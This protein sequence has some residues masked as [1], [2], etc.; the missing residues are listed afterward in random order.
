MEACISEEKLSLRSWQH[1]HQAGRDPRRNYL[2]PRCNVV[3]EILL[4]SEQTIPSSLN[5]MCD[6]DF[7][8][9]TNFLFGQILWRKD[10]PVSDPE[11]L[12]A[13]RSA[14][15]YAKVSSVTFN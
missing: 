4:C 1:L 7:V 14:N 3:Q 6:S 5:P 8:K 11:T 10:G 9:L 13:K 15:L 12:G 2:V